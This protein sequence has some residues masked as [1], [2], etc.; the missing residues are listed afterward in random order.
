[1]CQ[2]T[3]LLE[4][5]ETGKMIMKI[6]RR[7]HVYVIRQLKICV[8]HSTLYGG[9]SLNQQLI[10]NGFRCFFCVYYYPEKIIH[11]HKRIQC[12]YISL[13]GHVASN[14][15]LYFLYFGHINLLHS[16]LLDSK[17]PFWLSFLHGMFSVLWLVL[18]LTS[19]LY[20]FPYCL[21]LHGPK[22]SDNPKKDIRLWFTFCM[23]LKL[24]FISL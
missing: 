10:S 17:M 3:R 15:F 7:K 11:L 20:D 13:K 8:T 18:T 23:P 16:F 12:N 4:C 22:A 5:Q 9:D 14:Y 21:V 19:Y 1:M 2:S 24:I 6:T